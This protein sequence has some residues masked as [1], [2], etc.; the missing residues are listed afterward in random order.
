MNKSFLILIL[1]LAILSGHAQADTLTPGGRLGFHGMVVYGDGPYYLDHIPMLMAP[2]DFQ[3]IARVELKNSSGQP[4]TMDF[5]DQG[6]TFE[7]AG[8]FSLDDYIS[9]R[10]STFKGA[11]H[12]G[13]FEQGGPIIPGLESVQVQVQKVIFARQLP[14]NS[15]Q[16]WFEVSDRQNSFVI[17]VITP[18]RSMQLIMNSTTGKTLWCVQG[19][20]FGP[21]CK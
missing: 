4:I 1:G 10:L 8:N 11:I 7:P 14:T 19:P 5:S 21:P 18:A 3:V 9:G 6:F 16:A 13:G 2:H 15:N 20:D 12:K 17:N